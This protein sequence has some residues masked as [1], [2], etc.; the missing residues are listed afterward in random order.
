MYPTVGP[1][2][3]RW[4]TPRSAYCGARFPVWW[5][6]VRGGSGGATVP[7]LTFSSVWLRWTDCS[8]RVT[9]DRLTLLL[10]GA[11][12]RARPVAFLGWAHRA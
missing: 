3:H 6:F 7:L 9:E 5:C 2:G 1:D 12:P 8:G 10:P 4:R 11:M